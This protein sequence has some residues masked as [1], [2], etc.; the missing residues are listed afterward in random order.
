[1]IM[2]PIPLTLLGIIPGHALF[3]AAFTATSMIGW[4]ALAGIIVRNSILLVDF[5]VHEIANGVPAREAV[6]NSCKARTR[7]IL[8][9]AAALMAG[10]IVIMP[11]PIF[12]GM[13]IS[14][15]FGVFVST[16]LTLVVIP[17]GCIQANKSMCEIA[18]ARV[19]NATL[20]EVGGG[21]SVAIGQAGKKRGLLGKIGSLIAMIFYA[22]RGIVLL[23]LQLFRKKPHGGGGSGSTPPSTPPPKPTPT[24][25]PAAGTAA[26]AG[27]ASPG[28]GAQSAASAVPDNTASGAGTTTAAAKAVEPPVTPDAERSETAPAEKA[29]EK[30]Q[31]KPRTTT[32]KRAT[33]KKASRKPARGKV[34]AG[35]KTSPRRSPGSTK[36]KG[37][38]ADVNGARRGIRLKSLSDD[39]NDLDLG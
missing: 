2:A 9:T 30:A 5:S 15:L 12:R 6:I 20:A 34:A 28:G 38:E 23:I 21:P 10:S 37:N 18:C 26:P 4:I 31:G 39:D 29:P 35:R 16:I 17:L 11:D 8:I 25:A 14:L 3:N 7:P 27:S 32:K 19:P 22:L 33:K 36:A 24:P 1:L 13:G